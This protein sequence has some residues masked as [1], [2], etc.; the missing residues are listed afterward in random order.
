MCGGGYKI[1]KEKNQI[2]NIFHHNYFSHV[3]HAIEI[4]KSIIDV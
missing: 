1:P 2:G 3:I 4:F